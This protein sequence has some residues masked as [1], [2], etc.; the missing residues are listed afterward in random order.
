MYAQHIPTAVSV[1]ILSVVSLELAVGPRR[2][3]RQQYPVAA[4]EAHAST[5]TLLREEQDQ[6]LQCKLCAVHNKIVGIKRGSVE[7]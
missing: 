1:F 4:A 7:S 2:V 5:G 6:F 3:A